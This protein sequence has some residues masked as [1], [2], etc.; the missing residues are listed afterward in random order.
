M[1][2]VAQNKPDYLLL[3]SKFC[4]STGK[5]RK[6]D[7]LCVATRTLVKAVLNVSSTGCNNER[8]SFPT[9]SYS[10]IDNVLTSLLPG[11]LSGAQRLKCDDDG[12]QAAGVLPKL[13][14]LLCTPTGYSAAT[15][16]V[17]QIL[18][19]EDALVNGRDLIFTSTS[20]M[21]SYRILITEEY[22]KCTFIFGLLVCL[23]TTSV[24][25]VDLCRFSKN[26]VDKFE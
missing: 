19:H 1:Y 8:Q 12:K 9:L 11:L 25:V 10:A 18:V 13:N 5:T 24:K 7:N 26:S 23:C 2:R 17:P 21:I 6:C 14:S 3:L 20:A 16:L 15:C 4:I 22:K